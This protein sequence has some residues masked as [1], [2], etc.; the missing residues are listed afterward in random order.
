[1]KAF[2][3]H[4]KNNFGDM[5][6][7]VILEWLTG[8]KPTL[9]DRR[10]SGKVLAVGSVTHLV[11]PGD[12]V[13][14]SGWMRPE[15]ESVDGAGARWLAVRGPLTRERV[16]NAEVPEVYGDPGLLLPM[17]QERT[18][19]AAR[20]TGLAPHMVDKQL[21]RAGH[22]PFHEDALSVFID[23]TWPWPTVTRSVSG[24]ARIYSSSLHAIVCAEAYGIP[25]AWVPCKG[26]IGGDL[27]FRDYLLG[28]G[29]D[30]ACLKPYE[31]LPPI[32]DLE[33]IQRRLI[34]AAGPLKEMVK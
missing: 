16:R 9:A 33:G 21:G 31:F 17:I 12:T 18:K 30:P 22:S 5:L 27:K 13:W 7:P 20:Y 8:V 25:A 32:P 28:T 10:D 24:C 29:R 2:W 11:K 4:N 15:I 34:E 14:G 23:V 26:V 3:W 6:S 19:P 1:M